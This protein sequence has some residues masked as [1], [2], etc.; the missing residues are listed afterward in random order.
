MGRPPLHQHLLAPSSLDGKC[1]WCPVPLLSI[2]VVVVVFR[3]LGVQILW[4]AQE[5]LMWMWKCRV[6][7]RCR[8]LWALECRFHGRRKTVDLE[9]Q[10]SWQAQDCVDV[11]VQSWW[12]VQD[13]VGLGVQIS[14]QAQEFVMWKC[15]CSTLWMLNCR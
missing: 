3:G 4:Q 10:I 2:V 7:G 1:E 13:F 11:E 12:Q 6:G 8:T 15:R 9:V 14:W 5:F